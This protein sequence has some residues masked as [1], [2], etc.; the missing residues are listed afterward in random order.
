MI[1]F[2]PVKIDEENDSPQG[3][4]TDNSSSPKNRRRTL[5]VHAKHG[6]GEIQELKFNTVILAIG[7]KPCTNMLQLDKA[8]VCTQLLT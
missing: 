4:F 1:G 8:G 7:K 3:E 2:S 6:S 5:I